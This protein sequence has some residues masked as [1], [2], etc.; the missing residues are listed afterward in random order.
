M[1]MNA[2]NYLIDEFSEIGS[3]SSPLGNNLPE[4]DALFGEFF[5][6]WQ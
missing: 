1:Q 3:P 6:R 4:S 5:N 2:I